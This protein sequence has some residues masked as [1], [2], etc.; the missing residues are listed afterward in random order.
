MSV[1]PVSG[2]GG[3][4]QLDL[5]VMAAGMPAGPEAALAS[6]TAQLEE[7]ADR[8]RDVRRESRAA[9]RTAQREEIDEM[10]R[11]AIFKL[12]AGLVGASAEVAGGLTDGTAETLIN[13]GGQASSAV[14]GFYESDAQQEAK[15]HAMD[16]QTHAEQ[17]TDAGEGASRAERFADKALGHQEAIARARHEATMAAL[18]G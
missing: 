12:S 9:R 18:R 5:E 1:G 17:A 8:A 14:L 7:A 4:S 10:R 11:G 15:R 6:A 13:A 3:P 2:S 16:A